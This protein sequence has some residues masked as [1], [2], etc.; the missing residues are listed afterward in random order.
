[1]SCSR[2]VHANVKVPTAATC[3]ALFQVLLLLEPKDLITMARAS[4]TFRRA[5][6]NEDMDKNVWKHKRQEF[7]AP[8][9]PPGFSEAK[10]VAFLFSSFCYVSNLFFLSLACLTK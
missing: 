6:I 5:L 1:M 2:W 10:W 4:K 3:Q 7:G 9:P 8:D